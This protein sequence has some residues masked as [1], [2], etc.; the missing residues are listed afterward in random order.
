MSYSAIAKEMIRAVGKVSSSFSV[1]KHM[2]KLNGKRRWWFIV[3]APEKSLLEVDERWEHK[4]W[5]WQ[6]LQGKAGDFL[7]MDRVPSE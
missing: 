6:K 3:K 4:H 5:Q 7:G 1:M 2:D